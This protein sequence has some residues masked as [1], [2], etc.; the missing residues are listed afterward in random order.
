MKRYG[1]L[2]GLKSEFYD[3]YCEYHSNIWPEV[4]KKISECNITNYS[5]FHINGLLF[6]YYEYTGIN[7]DSDMKKMADDTKTQEWWAIMKPIQAPLDYRKDGEWWA[8]MNE[9]FHQD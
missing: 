4:E 7:F 6:S 3:L 1:Q 9:V 8:D 5:I 2:I